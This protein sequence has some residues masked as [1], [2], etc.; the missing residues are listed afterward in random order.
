MNFIK[1]RTNV[2]KTCTSG[3][4]LKVEGVLFSFLQNFRIHR[5]T[6]HFFG[7]SIIVQIQ[8]SGNKFKTIRAKQCFFSK[9]AHWNLSLTDISSTWLAIRECKVGFPCF[10]LV[11]LAISRLY[12]KMTVWQSLI[13]HIPPTTNINN[14]SY[15]DRI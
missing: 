10:L 1:D 2:C 13:F 3:D 7:F 5:F 14:R 12:A 11:N 4:R 9:R 15:L 6:D 8:Q